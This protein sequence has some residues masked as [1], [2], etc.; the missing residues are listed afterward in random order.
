MKALLSWC[1]GNRQ[2]KEKE[3][4]EGRPKDEKKNSEA[5]RALGVVVGAHE[6]SFSTQVCAENEF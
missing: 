1:W 2:E 3:M 6:N 5:R 4:E